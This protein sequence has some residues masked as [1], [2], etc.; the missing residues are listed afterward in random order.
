MNQ[1]SFVG[2]Y[3]TSPCILTE[4]A[5]VEPLSRGFHIH[6]DEK[7]IHPGIIYNDS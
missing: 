1:L 2:T 6:L 4:G 5:V 7:F 3:R